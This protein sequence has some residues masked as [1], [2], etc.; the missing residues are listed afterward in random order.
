MFRVGYCYGKFRDRRYKD[1]GSYASAQLYF[2]QKLQERR[3]DL[4]LYVVDD[5]V[6]DGVSDSDSDLDKN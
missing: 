5:E 2:L 1:F 6:L 4:R 3:P